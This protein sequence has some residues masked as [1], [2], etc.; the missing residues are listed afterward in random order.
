MGAELEG[1]AKWAKIRACAKYKLWA[2]IWEGTK[3]AKIR[4]RTQSLANL[5]VYNA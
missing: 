4:T 2:P 1:C 3:W 5:R